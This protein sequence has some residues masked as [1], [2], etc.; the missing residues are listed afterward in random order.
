MLSFKHLTKLSTAE[1]IVP[2]CLIP[3]TLKRVVEPPLQGAHREA[4][5]QKLQNLSFCW[6]CVETAIYPMLLKQPFGA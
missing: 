1:R 6:L 4:E 3:A 5:A 2:E